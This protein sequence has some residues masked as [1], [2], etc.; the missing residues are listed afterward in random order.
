MSEEKDPKFFS[1]QMQNAIF[2]FLMELIGEYRKTMTPLEAANTAADWMIS[3]A[4]TLKRE[5]E[6]LNSEYKP[7]FDEEHKG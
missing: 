4:N 7:I 5:A 1:S 2:Q 3:L 6:S